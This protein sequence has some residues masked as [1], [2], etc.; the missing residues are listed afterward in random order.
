MTDAEMA[1]G[2][3]VRPDTVRQL[4]EVRMNMM[5][6]HLE[7]LVGL[8]AERQAAMQETEQQL[9]SWFAQQPID[10]N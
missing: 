1:N 6:V 3:G 7:P 10:Q 5:V 8:L 2:M 4:R 9:R